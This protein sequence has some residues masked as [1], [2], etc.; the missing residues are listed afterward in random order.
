MTDVPSGVPKIGVSLALRGD[1]G[2]LLADAKAIEAAG[3]DSLWVF[4][5]DGIDQYVIAASL[6]AVT[7]RVRL[8]V[9]RMNPPSPTG[10]DPAEIAHATCA[11]I[12]RG[13]LLSAVDFTIS[14]V[15][16]EKASDTFDAARR[17]RPNVE[18][19]LR[20]PFPDGRAAW[21]ELRVACMDAGATGVVLPNDPRLIDLLRNPDIIEDRSDLKLSFG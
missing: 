11:R 6:A 3:A 13:R 20:S 21:V 2:E 14:D 9:P 19:W 1:S 5:A 7:W 18:C 10:P 16:P 4:G 8:V 15:T 17:L 12:A